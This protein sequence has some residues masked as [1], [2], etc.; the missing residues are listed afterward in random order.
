MAKNNRAFTLIELMLASAMMVLLFA[1]AYSLFHTGKLSWDSISARQQTSLEWRA[2]SERMDRDLRNCVAFS[3]KETRFL[4]DADNLSLFT[5]IDSYSN[6]SMLSDLGRVSYAFREKNLLRGCLKGRLALNGSADAGYDEFSRGLE[7][8]SFSYGD[9]NVSSGNW[10]WKD[11]W[12]DSARLPSCVS[13]KASFGGREP[14]SFER[15]IYLPAGG[16]R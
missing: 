3:S 4:G 6:G 10:E 1:G 15:T 9:Y 12:E 8:F 2:V 14:V 16:A 11:T 13:V 5:V 7:S